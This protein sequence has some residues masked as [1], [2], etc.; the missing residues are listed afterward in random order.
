MSRNRRDIEMQAKAFRLYAATKPHD[1]TPSISVTNATM[2]GLYRGHAMASPR[3]DADN[4]LQH[5]SRGL[6][7]QTERV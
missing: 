5:F 1:A 2:K 4:H 3:A 7:V 6:T